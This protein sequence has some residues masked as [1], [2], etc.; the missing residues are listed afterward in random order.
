MPNASINR[1]TPRIRS[2][3]GM[4]DKIPVCYLHQIKLLSTKLQGVLFEY[5]TRGEPALT[6]CEGRYLSRYNI[7]LIHP[8]QHIVTAEQYRILS[9]SK[10]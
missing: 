6:D 3:H 10:L 8:H 4:H 9:S 5:T 2:D 7:N 1:D